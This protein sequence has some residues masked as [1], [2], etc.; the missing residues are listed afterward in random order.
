MKP[1]GVV[2]WLCMMLSFSSSATPGIWKSPKVETVS[3]PP[4]TDG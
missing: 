1:A 4:S 2:S 3:S